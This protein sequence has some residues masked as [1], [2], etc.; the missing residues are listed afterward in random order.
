MAW[1]GGLVRIEARVWRDDLLAPLL[2]M[3]F[4]F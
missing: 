3:L 2:L 1:L 4:F